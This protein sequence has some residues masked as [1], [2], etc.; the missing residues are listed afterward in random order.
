[1]WGYVG[2]GDPVGL[3][4]MFYYKKVLCKNSLGTTELRI[5]QKANSPMYSVNNILFSIVYTIKNHNK[6]FSIT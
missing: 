3:E 1:M 6:H 4:N 5:T 2:G